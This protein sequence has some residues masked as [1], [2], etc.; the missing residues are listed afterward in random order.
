MTVVVTAI[1]ALTALGNLDQTWKSIL[2][3][4]TGLAPL[5]EGEALSLLPVGRATD[6]QGALGSGKR[7][8]S[9]LGAALKSVPSLPAESALIVSTTKGAVDELLDNAEGSWCGQPWDMADDLAQRLGLTGE[10]ITVSAACASG[11]LAL[12]NAAQRLVGRECDVALVVGVDLLSRFVLSGFA[13]LHA[14]SDEPCRPFDRKRKGLSL[15]EAAAYAVLTRDDVA[16]EK[17]WPVMARLSGWGTACDAQHITAPCRKASGLI[18][19]IRQAVNNDLSVIGGINAHG[20]GTL[21]NDAME[22]YGFSSLWCG[23]PPPFHSIKGAVGHTLGAAGVLEAGIAVKSLGAGIIPPTVGL[24]EPDIPAAVGNESVKLSCPAI[25]SCNS[26]FGG[27][28]ACVVLQ[29]A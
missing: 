15:G 29:A 25:L 8:D 17:G 20:T 11:T 26:G 5:A 21:F 2:Q 18:A 1:D 16:R 27:I 3:G 13:K 12:I 14:L 7:L 22:M 4:K 24:Q 6:V 28:N 9:L 10:R 23:A 19:A